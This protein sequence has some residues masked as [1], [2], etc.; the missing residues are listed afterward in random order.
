MLIG[1]IIL[2]HREFQKIEEFKRLIESRPNIQLDYETARIKWKPK[3][4]IYTRLVRVTAYNAD[5]RQ[6]DST[7]F[8]AA[9]G[10]RVRPG[11]IAVSR[12]LEKIGLTRGK[13]IHVDGFGYGKILDRMHKRKR[14]QIDIFM[15]NNEDAVNFG[16]RNLTIWWRE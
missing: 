11:M 9:W 15:E 6:T 4:I 1:M 10:D 8:T 14:N 7:P 5:Q 12:D 13:L 2:D 3:S 16:V